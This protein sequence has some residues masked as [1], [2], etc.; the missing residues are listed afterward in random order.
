MKSTT[1]NN[2][3][4]RQ[5]AKILKVLLYLPFLIKGIVQDV[6]ITVLG[7][8]VRDKEDALRAA[9]FPQGSA[10]LLCSH[11]NAFTYVNVPS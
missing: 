6:N 2:S 3:D 1:Q 11:S 10:E 4:L 7:N 9:V 5:N 8:V